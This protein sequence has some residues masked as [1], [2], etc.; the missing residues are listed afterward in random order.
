MGSLV[1]RLQH[2][3]LEDLLDMAQAANRDDSPAMNEIVRR[4]DPLVKR[5]VERRRMR[6][7][8]AADAFVAA[9]LA[10]VRAVRNHCGGSRSFPAYVKWYIRG[11]VSDAVKSMSRNLEEPSDD[12]IPRPFDADGSSVDAL[13]AEMQLALCSLGENTRQ[14][15]WLRYGEGYSNLEL[16]EQAGVTPSAMSQRLATALRSM[17]GQIPRDRSK[18]V[19]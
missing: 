3:A 10:I 13:S 15:V 1:F 4:F 5:C 9:Q 8:D 19:A 7:A 17:A 18:N 16:A 6:H 12:V 14:V 11:A 2:A